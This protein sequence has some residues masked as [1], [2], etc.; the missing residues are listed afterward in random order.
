[1]TVL[2]DNQRLIDVWFPCAAVDE[3]CGNPAGS[4]KNEKAIFTWF[5]SR[6]I[7]QARAA[8]ACALLGDD[9]GTRRAI[10][11]ALRGSRG[12]VDKLAEAVAAR[13]PAGRPVVLDVFSGRGIIPLEAA[14]LGAVAV[15]LDLLPVATLAGRL[16]AD[17]P[18]RDWQGEPSLPWTAK[19][20]E[21]LLPVAA[22]RAR[23]VADLRVLLAEVGDRVRT[24]VAPY[25]PANPD[26]S[27][28][29]GYLWGISIPCDGCGRRFPLVGSM[30]LRHPYTRS[31]DPGQALHLEIDGDN[32]RAEVIDGPPGQPPTYSSAEMAGGKKRKGKS[33][34]CLFCQHVHSLEAVKAKGFN[35]EYRDELLVAA[36]TEGE[37]KKVFRTP[38]PEERAAAAKVDL[39]SLPPF[40]PYTA[41]P[42]ERI[43]EGNVHTVMASGYGYRTFGALM[44]DRQTLHFIETARAIRTCHSEML[45]AGLSQEYSDALVSFAGA[46]LVRRL[47]YSTR[48]ANLQ[49]FGKPDGTGNNN[50]AVRHVFAKEAVVAFQFDYF[51][52]GPSSG[53]GTWASLSETGLKPLETHLRDL[54]GRPARFRQANAMALPYRD[55][56]V[57]AVVTD[58]PYYDMIEYADASDLFHVWL[59]RVLFDIEPD[60]FGDHA[61][62]TK[63]GL[64]NKDDEIIVRRVHEPGRI[65]H[66]RDFYEASLSKAFSEARRVLRPDGHLVVVFGHSD[67]DA[68]RRLLRALHDAGFVVT[69]SWPS[70]TESA[71]TGVAS[72]KVTVTIGCRV[73]PEGRHAATAAQ[74]DRE[75]TGVIK[76]RVR[77]WAREGLA[78]SDQMMAAYGPAMEVYG[79]YATVLLTDGTEAPLDRYLTLARRAVREAT[80]LRLDA[81]P[82]ETFDPLTRLAVFWLRLHGRTNVPKGEARFMAQA[83]NLRLEDV[84]DAL[85]AESTAGFRLL[86]TPPTHVGPDS[87]AFDVARAVAGAFAD[88]GTEA[89]AMVLARTERAPDDEHLWAVVGELVAQLPPDDGTAKALTAVQRNTS[90]IQNLA[91]GIATAQADADPVRHPTL[92]AADQEAE[93]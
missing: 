38:R 28:P 63:G 62:G 26:G 78:L 89:A 20:T 53:P 66:D 15:G 4:G 24:A 57:D 36:D 77:T 60:L 50:L 91:K 11:E 84:R 48:G 3:A 90:A 92:F 40:G 51:E 35:G 45:G 7:A 65:R 12:A 37:T 79:R 58:P 18:M 19:G 69:S 83:D 10:E 43:P 16:L 21:G 5:A 47:K 13:Y 41:V 88:G 64:Q 72:I 23:L 31:R 42:D 14:R 6:P 22:G 46:I 33:G 1:M 75:V 70:R 61:A 54:R 29:W 80:A 44:C 27:Q 2:T 17:Y 67:P 52:T 55:S 8:V 93:R 56:S 86:V 74:V 71:N 30:V 32:W 59:K 25:Y 9:P 81:L 82:L 39:S 85:L 87:P 76:G 68:W 49:P 73:A 34:R